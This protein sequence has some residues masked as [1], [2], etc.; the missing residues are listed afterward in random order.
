[1]EAQTDSQKLTK[2]GKKLL[3]QKRD[4][5]IN[6][7]EGDKKSLEERC[8]ELNEKCDTLHVKHSKLK[9]EI[10]ILKNQSYLAE[11]ISIV[12]KQ[13]LME[14]IL[15]PVTKENFQSMESLHDYLACDK[16]SK[17]H[18]KTA[19][20]SFIQKAAALAKIDLN[21]AERYINIFRNLKRDRNLAQHP[22]IYR[23]KLRNIVNKWDESF[24]ET[25]EALLAFVDIANI[26]DEEEEDDDFS[27]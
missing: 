26:A 12:H 4:K 10:E 19:R 23:N 8:D 17:V 15:H 21:M 24:V 3:D 25:K 1:M 22:K 16:N 20:D 9:S 13:I 6:E 5:I 11:Y 14:G 2:Q 7:L 18:K 27:V